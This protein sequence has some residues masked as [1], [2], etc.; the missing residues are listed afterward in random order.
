M[1]IVV[2]ALAL[3]ASAICIWMLESGRAGLTVTA[4]AIPDGPPATIHEPAGEA[5]VPVVVVAHGFA[6]SRPLMEPLAL[7]LARS[8]YLVVSFDFMGHGRNPRP[9]TGDVTSVDG[10]TR[11][12]VE[13]VRS[14]ARAALAHP[15]AD[16]R[17]AYLGHSMASDIIIRAAE[18]GPEVGAIVALSAFSQAVTAE[19][20]P[21]LLLITGAWEGG[22]AKAAEDMLHLADPQAGLGQTVGDPQVG[23]ARRAV[24]APGVEHVGVLY[25]RAAQHEAVAWLNATFGRDG[26]A[27]PQPRGLWIMGLLAALALLGWPAAHALSAGPPRPSLRTAPFLLAALLPAIA[28]PLALA[29]IRTQILP[30]L[31]ADY[32]VLHFAA[33]AAIS[34]LILWRAGHLRG[35]FPLSVL[36]LAALVAVLAIGVIGGLLN[37]Y[38]ASFVPTEG[39]FLIIAGL[40]I[41]AVPYLVSDAVLTEG[42][43]A[44]IWRVLVARG[45][46]LG[47][48]MGAVA[49]NFDRL[50]FLLI[51]LPV[52]LLFFLIFGTMSGW[53]GRRTGLPAVA[54]I[55]FGLMLAWALGV[56]FPLFA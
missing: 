54:G 9:M 25:S 45:A 20:P 10:T 40:V 29:P 42:G 6:G 51:I 18:E 53:I 15:R 50:M 7:T 3:M 23:P 31:V 11:L 12:L 21:N 5:A 13:E 46:F 19:F 38:V 35:Q 22:L 44:A 26:M 1:R 14:V 33:Y 30:V 47:S 32:L 37:R 28:V 52:I 36:P 48:L 41:G 24:L 8:G 2:A 55:G 16:G 4:F 49:L 34:L 39:R 17:L 27:E 56:T 43:R